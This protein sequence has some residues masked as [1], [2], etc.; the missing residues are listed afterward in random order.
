MMYYA[1][2]AN[3]RL[4]ELSGEDTI[5]FL[6]GLISN[7]AT[8]LKKGETIYAALLSP[9]GRFLHDFFLLPWKDS[10]LLDCDVSSL[11]DL[12]QRLTMYKLRSRVT[13]TPRD[14]MA[15]AAIW[16]DKAPKLSAFPDPRMAQL[17]WRIADDVKTIQTA[18]EKEGIKALGAEAY[19]QL[20]LA[21]GI[22]D[23]AHDMVREKSLLLEF[24]FEDL[25]GVDFTKGCYVGQEVTARTKYRGQLRR[26]IYHV[27][28]DNA[29][30][31][32]G[33]AVTSDGAAIGELRSSRDGI[34]LALLEVA[35]VEKAHA[36]G[37]NFEAG[38]MGFKATL[39]P[40]ISHPPKA[41]IRGE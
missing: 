23:G 14:D 16:G 39:P 2:L 17:G 38:N 35:A 40:W 3:R 15:V 18:C 34:G 6:Q 22:P 36:E 21:S 19:E 8:R 1:H 10:V 37:K 41:L 28:A 33:T 5:V 25:H 9:Q 20:R 31:A 27:H 11:P 12:T 26:F 30:P 24:G 32:C 13:L 4:I 29:L 7:D